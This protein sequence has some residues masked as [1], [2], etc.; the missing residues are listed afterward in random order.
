MQ[1]LAQKQYFK[2]TSKPTFFEVGDEPLDRLYEGG[3]LEIIDIL[4]AH[5]FAKGSKHE[6]AK[7]LFAYLFSASR[8]GHLCVKISRSLYPPLHLIWTSET[9]PLPKQEEEEIEELIFHAFETL[10]SD[11]FQQNPHLIRQGTLLYLERNWSLES[12]TLKLFE[13]WERELPQLTFQDVLL[14]DNLL[15]E[16]QFAIRASLNHTLSFITGGPGVGKT[17]TASYLLHSFLK[18]YPSARVALVAPTGKAVANLQG[19]FL[20]GRGGLGAHLNLEVFT[21]HKLFNQK[22]YS[23]LP[24]DLILV[25]ESSMINLFFMHRLLTFAKPR[26]RILFLGDPNQLPPIESG[27]IFQDLLKLTRNQSKLT[28]CIRSE[29][30]GLIQAAD[31]I[32]AGNL[33][34]FVS[35]VQSAQLLFPLSIKSK[36][37]FYSHILSYYSDEISSLNDEELIHSFQRFKLLSPV[38][39]GP[40]GVDQINKEFKDYFA[41]RGIH[42]ILITSN[43][44]ALELFNGDTGVLIGHEKALFL[45]RTTSQSYYDLSKQVRVIPYALLP[46]FEYAYC[47]SVH[48]SQGSEYEKIAL[49]LPPTS[50]V[51]GREVLYTAITRAKKIFEIFSDLN[52]LIRL[53]KGTALRFSGVQAKEMKYD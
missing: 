34:A 30:Q 22:I 16:Q 8:Q 23:F 21:L 26:S 12:E 18:E 49:L 48:K 31:W 42:P 50:E 38:R 19:Y 45:P 29:S 41:H 51:F 4:A 27:F 44:Y 46:S 6:G 17:Y 32:Q 43:D 35:Y 24:Y 15:S 28:K 7:L 37:S 53:F 33:E 13:K 5:F 2:E 47:I 10:S 20:K 1:G 36:E 25:D 39:K 40:F 9:T 3:F 14:D 52:T 11:F